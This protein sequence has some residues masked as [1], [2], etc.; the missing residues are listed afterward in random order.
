MLVDPD[1][2]D[3]RVVIE[4]NTITI[5]GLYITNN[6]SKKSATNA[7]N[8]WNEMSGNYQ[9]IVTDKNGVLK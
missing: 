3:Y 6:E 1:G 4:N 8:Q 2:R 9:Y 5:S 7:V